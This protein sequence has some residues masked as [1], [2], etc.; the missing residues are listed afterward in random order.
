MLI[1]YG[2]TCYTTYTLIL[3]FLIFNILS[4]MNR[5]QSIWNMKCPQCRQGD[6]FVKPFEFSKPLNMHKYCEKCNKNLE[7]E[8]GY[9]FGAMFISYGWTAWLC[10]FTVGFT[11]IF[12]K[13]SIGQSFALLIGSMAISFFWV[14]RISR[15]IY[16]NVDMRYDPEI[17]KQVENK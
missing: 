10:I 13:W 3:R 1:F 16:A 12:L 11:M 2:N 8:P 6:L 14:M 9:Y 7:P 5:M 4:T 15:S 17:A